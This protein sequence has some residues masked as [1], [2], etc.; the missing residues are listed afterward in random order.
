MPLVFGNSRVADGFLSNSIWV[1]EKPTNKAKNN[2]KPDEFICAP[3]HGPIHEP[4]KI[5]GANNLTT[6]HNTAPR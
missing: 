6:G 5:P 2:A 4:I 1:A 3:N